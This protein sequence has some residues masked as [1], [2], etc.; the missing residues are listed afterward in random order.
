MHCAKGH[1]VYLVRFQRE[2]EQ[3]QH[4]SCVTHAEAAIVRKV[5]RRHPHA[6]SRPS[7]AVAKVAGR[8]P[9]SPRQISAGL[10]IR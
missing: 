1:P 3:D 10:R 5:M 9:Y 8:P 7:S 4:P 6:L 2:T